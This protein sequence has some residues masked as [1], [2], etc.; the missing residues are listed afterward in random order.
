MR[1]RYATQTQGLPPTFV[2]F[3]NDKRLFGKDY[4]RYLENRLRE[5]FGFAGTPIRLLLRAR[6]DERAPGES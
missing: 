2:L 6:R 4:L 3:V 5:C 1:I